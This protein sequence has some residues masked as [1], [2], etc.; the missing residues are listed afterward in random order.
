M[1]MFRLRSWRSSSTNSGARVAALM[2]ASLMRGGS[3]PAG[4]SGRDERVLVC[5]VR[6]S[7]RSVWT[8]S[9]GGS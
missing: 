9:C 8:T 5:V 1:D 4:S 3:P 2:A 7:A 6:V